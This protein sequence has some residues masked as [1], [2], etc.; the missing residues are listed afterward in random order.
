MED[1]WQVEFR[2]SLT[3]TEYDDFLALLS[4]LQPCHLTP[5]DDVIEWAL[6][7]NN[8]IQLNIYTPALLIV[9][10]GLEVLIPCRM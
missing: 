1:E 7:K 8:L 6:E 3:P 4:L 5:L 10:L 9:V 2:R